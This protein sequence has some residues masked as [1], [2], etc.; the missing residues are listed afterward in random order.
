MEES[1]C[2]LEATWSSVNLMRIVSDDLEADRF[3]QLH[4]RAERAF[5]SRHDSK[6]IHGALKD[7]LAEHAEKGNLDQQRLRIVERYLLEYKHNGFELE[8]KKKTELTVTWMNKL[9]EAVRDYSTRM[10]VSCSAS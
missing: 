4:R 9:G 5:L 3:L 1:R 2:R 8:E 7:L 6:V 10:A